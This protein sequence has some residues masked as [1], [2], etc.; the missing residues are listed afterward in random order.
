MIK[1][2]FQL[3]FSIAWALLF[4]KRVPEGPISAPPKP[5]PN[6]PSAESLRDGHELSDAS[7]K[8]VALL[9]FSLMAM[10]A[11]TMAVLGWMYSHLYTERRAIPVLQIQA[12]FKFAPRA[13]TSIA[14][15]WETIDARAHQRLD[16]YGWVDRQHRTVHIPIGRA[17]DLLAK[18]GLPARE[19]KTPPFPPPEDEKLPFMDLESTHDATNFS[20]K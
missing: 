4:P 5:D 19:G 13:K 9:V 18:E 20:P 12:T 8:V 11:V 15:D 2:L 14:G 17:M 16:G 10:I 6:A 3:V 7:P 1:I